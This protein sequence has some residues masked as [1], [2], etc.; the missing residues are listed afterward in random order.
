MF[1]LLYWLLTMRL[2]KSLVLNQLSSLFL[3]S[4]PIKHILNKDS[5]FNF[6]IGKGHTTISMLDSM[7][8]IAFID[9][10]INPSHDSFAVSFIIHV[11]SI[12]LIP[13]RPSKDSSAPLLVKFVL[14]LIG[15]PNRVF[16]LVSF[17][18][19]TFSVFQPIL[20]F[21]NISCFVVPS[22]LSPA[23]WTSFFVFSCVSISIGKDIC[24]FTLL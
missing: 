21:S 9:W 1:L 8:P 10:S 4:F 17:G 15:S 13:R 5:F 3:I 2:M 6:T 23:V 18:P 7:I 16:C 19:M 24:S 12:V 14:S 22:I 20:P 11:F